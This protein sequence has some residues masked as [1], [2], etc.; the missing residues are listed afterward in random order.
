MANMSDSETATA[1]HPDQYFEIV[2]ALADPSSS[3]LLG[4]ITDTVH[5]PNYVYHTALALL[6]ARGFLT[7]P[8]AL[9]AYEKSLALHSAAPKIQAFYQL[10]GDASKSAECGSWIEW[11][12]KQ[13]CGPDEI[14]ELLSSTPSN[15]FV[16]LFPFD[17]VQK[18]P[19]AECSTP[20]VFYASLGSQNFHSLHS[21]LRSKAAQTEFCYI[22]RYAP[23]QSA[24]VSNEQD[25][26]PLS[27]YGVAL[28]LKVCR[29]FVVSTKLII[30]FQK[31]DYL[32]LDD[33][34]PRGQGK[35]GASSRDVFVDQ[36]P[37]ESEGD[38]N[39]TEDKRAWVDYV[40]VLLAEHPHQEL[41]LTTPLTEQEIASLPYFATHLIASSSDPLKALVHLSQNFPKHAVSLAR[42]W[43]VNRTE[44]LGTKYENIE[45]EV[46]AN[47]HVVAGAGN[48]AWINGVSVSENDMNPFRYFFYSFKNEVQRLME[49][50]AACFDYFVGSVK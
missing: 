31:M 46:Q 22:M 17:H 34:G 7:E 32:A 39:T 18:Q 23:P 27:G 37:P 14:E 45:S 21:Y 38:Q 19:N 48:M 41:D 2:D 20:L 50:D 42:R 25:R 29:L 24:P 4:P 33:R 35:L 16:R 47:M 15:S 30:S 5:K 8:N 28:D 36:L 43:D 40:S 26:N 9:S 44:E 11:A 3:G 13:V 49:W 10:F 6:Q 12:G 1:E